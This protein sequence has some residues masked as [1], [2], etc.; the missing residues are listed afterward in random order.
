MVV[1]QY[2]MVKNI[3]L[4][5]QEPLCSAEDPVEEAIPDE[6]DDP[7]KGME[8]ECKNA[9]FSV[10]GEPILDNVNIHIKPGT[11]LAIVGTSGA[12]KSTFISSLLGFA[13]LD[14]GDMLINGKPIDPQVIATVR[15][16]STWLD[17]QVYLFKNTII[18]NITYGNC[19]T[20]HMGTVLD[21]A[22]LWPLIEGLPDSIHTECG[23]AGSQLS[24][25]EGQRIRLARALNKPDVTL[26]LLDE[27][28]RGLDKPTRQ[29]L[30]KT[31]RQKWKDITIICVIHDVSEAMQFDQV[32]VL[33]EG[34]VIEQGTPTELLQQNGSLVRL[35]NHETSVA[36]QWL[37]SPKWRRVSV[38]EGRIVE[39]PHT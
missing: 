13:K 1:Q 2:P 39:R 35:L 32:A 28:F 36:S 31:V 14:R 23:E 27:P 17:P 34:Q 10:E 24:G 12:G 25:G 30:M 16:H 9:D 26:A 29:L 22:N 4:R 19:H 37:N 5:L 15:K 7:P 21:E 20:G 6:S 11:H 3:I 18:E 8:I 33:E 38:H